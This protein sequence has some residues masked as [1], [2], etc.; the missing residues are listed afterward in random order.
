[1]LTAV[2][3][4]SCQPRAFFSAFSRADARRRQMKNLFYAVTAQKSTRVTGSCVGKFLSD[5]ENA[6]VVAKSSRLELY[7]LGEEGLVP[8]TEC[9]LYG[10][11]EAAFLFRVAG[12]ATDR[13]FVLTREHQVLALGVSREHVIEELAVGSIGDNV[14]ERAD[15]A[16][17]AYTVSRE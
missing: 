8:V 2:V 10:H 4:A 3:C 12:E 11:V 17:A 7:T 1:V 16:L 5:K 9:K 6:L 15:I 13:L 14:G